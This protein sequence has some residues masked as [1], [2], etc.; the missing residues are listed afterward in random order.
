MV[1]ALR[2]SL[3]VYKLPR[4]VVVVDRVPRTDVGKADYAAAR[5]LFEAHS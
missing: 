4:A 3:A 1:D 5:N 2:A